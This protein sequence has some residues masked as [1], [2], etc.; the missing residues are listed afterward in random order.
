M[1]F[2]IML[3]TGFPLLN[4]PEDTIRAAAYPSVKKVAVC[5]AD[6][7]IIKEP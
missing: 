3:L 5:G 2:I 6:Y 7:D 1:Y 4:H